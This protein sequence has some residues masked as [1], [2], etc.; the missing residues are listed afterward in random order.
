[1]GEGTAADSVETGGNTGA[2]VHQLLDAHLHLES[3]EQVQQTH[4]LLLY[5]LL[6]GILIGLEGQQHRLVLLLVGQGSQVLDLLLSERAL[7]IDIIP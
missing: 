6:E 3:L 4:L 5:F 7:H 2:D 1:M